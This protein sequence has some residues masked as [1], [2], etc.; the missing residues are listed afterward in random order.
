MDL[1][2]LGPIGAIVFLI[3]CIPT[4]P[5]TFWQGWPF[6]MVGSILILLSNYKSQKGAK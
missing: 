4:I 5:S 6:W 1:K 3:G 2:I